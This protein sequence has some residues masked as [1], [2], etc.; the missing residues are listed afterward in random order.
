LL[1]KL[2]RSIVVAFVINRLEGK[3]LDLID[4]DILYVRDV[5]VQ[6]AR[7]VEKNKDGLMLSQVQV[8]LLYITKLKLQLTPMHFICDLVIKIYFTLSIY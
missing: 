8:H 5:V 6:N 4:V 7:Y 2:D 1:N 3:K